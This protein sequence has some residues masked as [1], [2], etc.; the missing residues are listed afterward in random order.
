MHYVERKRRIA[1]QNR[2]IASLNEQNSV[3]VDKTDPEKNTVGVEECISTDKTPAPQNVTLTDETPTAEDAAL[4]DEIPE[5]ETL[6]STEEN[7]ESEP[8]P[9]QKI[10]FC[11]KCGRKTDDNPESRFCA[12]CG[13]LIR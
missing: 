13:T 10:F 5:A 3:F 7:S 11:P 4:N 6:S 12:G 1:A 9:V 8:P 2:Y